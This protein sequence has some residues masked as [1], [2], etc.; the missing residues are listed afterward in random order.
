MD[1]QNILQVNP[2]IKISNFTKFSEIVVQEINNI[3]TSPTTYIKKIKKFLNNFN[4]EDNVL[5]INGFGMYISEGKEIFLDAI[6]F[7]LKA[8]P[9]S[10]LKFSD[11]VCKSADELLGLLILHDGIPDMTESTVYYD[12]E[13]RM[14]H[15]GAAFGELDELIDFGTFDPM[16][17]VLNFILCDGDKERKERGIV[18]N[19]NVRFC[20][21]ASG[22]LPSDKVCTV[23]NFAEKFYSPGESIPQSV[24]D[25]YTE[26]VYVKNKNSDSVTPGGPQNHDMNYHT[27]SHEIPHQNG[28]FNFEENYNNK[29]LTEPNNRNFYE[30]LPIFESKNNLSE[31]AEFEDLP[32]G[33]EKI[34]ITEKVVK[35]KTTGKEEAIVKKTTYY[36]NGRSEMTL[37]K[38]K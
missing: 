1:V 11:G 32:E 28:N 20:G 34:K 17:V 31:S 30:G 8:K 3:R 12:L 6:K 4:E 15:Y 27:F 21:V 2:A 37:F 13:K 36:S 9:L 33:V 38:K 23:I 35:N 24:I 16:Y 26:T 10:A 25:R 7:L 29:C 5:N 18:F 19:P 22:L 14:N